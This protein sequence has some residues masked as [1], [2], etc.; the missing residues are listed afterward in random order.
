LNTDRD[1][2]D[3]PAVPGGGSTALVLREQPD[4]VAAVEDVRLQKLWLASQRR[5]WHS[6]AVLGTNDDVDTMRIAELFAKLSWSYTGK[7]SCVLDLRELRLRLV[8]Y[9]QQ[10][11]QAQVEAGNCV[12]VALSSTFQNPT[13]IPIARSVDAVILCIDM[14]KASIQAA[15]QTL[16]EVGRD[17]VLGAIVL[18]ERRAKRRDHRDKRGTRDKSE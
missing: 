9:Q 3:G 14:G 16:D 13:S 18:R 17:R 4:A 10:E 5:E 15:E 2:E 11:I 6:L 1:I 12:V 7:P 8:E